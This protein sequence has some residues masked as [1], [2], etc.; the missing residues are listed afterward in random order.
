[1]TEYIAQC[2]IDGNDTI[3]ARRSAERV[4]LAP[5][6]GPEVYLDTDKARTFARGILA[7][8]DEIDGGE[9]VKIVRSSAVEVG[10]RVRVVRN[11][12]SFEGNEN[13]GRVGI[14][15][16]ITPEDAQSHRVS[17]SDDAYGWWCAEVELVE[18]EPADTRPKVGDRLRV[19]EDNPRFCPV[20]T[21]D[22]ITVVETDYDHDG[23]DCVRFVHGDDT[24]RWFIPLTAVEPVTDEEPLADWE[25]DLIESAEAAT[26]SP[27][28]RYV[29]EA[30]ALLTD[31][32]HTG[33]DVVTLAVEL[34]RRS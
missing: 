8:T 17:F 27:F 2:A 1:M 11:A 21:G 28:A 30:K 26:R 5:R 3:T 19:T 25:R 18:D 32:D 34:D 22:V 31:T 24:Y 29:D 7:L 4:E 13:V 16:E 14:L 6:S 10:D 9:V 20:V 23:A 15:K 33:A 12:Y